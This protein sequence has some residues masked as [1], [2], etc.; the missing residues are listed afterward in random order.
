MANMRV[1]SVQLMAKY[2][3]V[4]ADKVSRQEWQC[5]VDRHENGT[6]FHTPYMYDVFSASAEYQAYAFFALDVNGKI[7]GLLTGFYQTVKPGLFGF[8]SRRSVLLQAPIFDDSEALRLLLVFYLSHAK[9]KAVHSEVRNHYL[10]NQYRQVCISQGFK[11]EGHYNIVKIIPDTYEMLWKET[12]RKRKDGINKAKKFGFEVCVNT[13]KSAIDTFYNLLKHKYLELKLP[14]PGKLFFE[15][16]LR[17]DTQYSC[18]FFE[19]KDA[20]VVRVSLLA[21]VYSGTL[22]AFYIGTD[23]DQE[24]LR[25]RPVDF[26]YYEVMRWCV[27]NSVTH[28]D[29]MGAGKPGKEYGVRDFKLQYGGDLVDYGRFIR[30]HSSLKYCIAKIGFKILQ[31]MGKIQ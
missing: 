12:G 28:F 21:F 1:V 27:T 30:V 25:K 4:T 31:R 9:R 20:S 13:D 23:Q 6:V 16:C 22:Y 2:V 7:C 14:I 26:F 29:W 10:D 15:N 18:M 11:W 3:I 8:L 24:F 5:Y 17:L 19:L